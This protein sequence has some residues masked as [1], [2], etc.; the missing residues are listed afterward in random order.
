[1]LE[2]MLLRSTYSASQ[3]NKFDV[4]EKYVEFLVKI[5]FFL[6]AW[7]VYGLVFLEP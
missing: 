6:G 4:F 5:C 7:G 1:M 3:I 2:F